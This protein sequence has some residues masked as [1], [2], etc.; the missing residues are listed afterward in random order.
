MTYEMFM[1]RSGLFVRK[2]YYES[3][4]LPLMKASIMHGMTEQGF[5]K[6]I[7]GIIVGATGARFIRVT[8]ANITV[9]TDDFYQM[10]D[11]QGNEC[12]LAELLNSC[13]DTI[14]D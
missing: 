12:T 4:I 3:G 1:Q 5:F 7:R 6:E 13:D 14:G 11:W 10:H 9:S 8:D 2:S